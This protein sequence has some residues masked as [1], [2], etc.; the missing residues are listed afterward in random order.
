M[1]FYRL[2][3]VIISSNVH[4][5]YAISVICSN[6][7]HEPKT[8][9]QSNDLRR[10]QRAGGARLNAKPLGGFRVHHVLEQLPQHWAV[11]M[12]T[13]RLNSSGENLDSQGG[14]RRSLEGSAQGHQLVENAAQCPDV[15]LVAVLLTPAQLW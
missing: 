5:V 9:R 8:A 7:S 3:R 13:G 1:Q 11:P 6:I 10:H 15:A 14:H 2:A 12:L 4:G